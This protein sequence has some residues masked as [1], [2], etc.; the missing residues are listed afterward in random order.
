M[1]DVE[2]NFS[3]KLPA[4]LL[5][6]W[7]ALMIDVEDKGGKFGHLYVNLNMMTSIL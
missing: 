2:D 7:Q 4:T 5:Q 3:V 6:C 1:I